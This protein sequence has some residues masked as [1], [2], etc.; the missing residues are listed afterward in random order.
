MVL[1]NGGHD[2]SPAISY[3]AGRE[4]ADQFVIREEELDFFC[5]VSGASEP[6]T[7]LASMLS[8]KSLR[9]VPSSAS[10]GLVAPIISRFWQWRF[11]LQ[12]LHNH[13]A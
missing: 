11:R 2:Y 13:W 5:C 10:A 1:K 9:M 8:A 7:E 4:L 6:C 3:Q 12:N